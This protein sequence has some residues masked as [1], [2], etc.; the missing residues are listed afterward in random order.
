MN[1][2]TIHDDS[3]TVRRKR[4]WN[5]RRADTGAASN[6]RRSSERK[7]VD[8]AV[9]IALNPMNERNDRNNQPSPRRSRQSPKSAN[10]PSCAVSQNDAPKIASP[11]LTPTSA[12]NAARAPSPRSAR[13]ARLRDAQYDGNN[14][15]G[16]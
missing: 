4:A 16:K 3:P 9:T 11:T 13:C 14:K 12:K 1:T 10:P 7:N 15:K 5:T 6:R 8:S 2:T